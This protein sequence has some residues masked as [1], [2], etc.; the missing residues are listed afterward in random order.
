MAQLWETNQRALQA[1]QEREHRER[2]DQ[3][4]RAIGELGDGYQGIF[5]R[6]RV[7]ELDPNSPQYRNRDAI[8]HSH[9]A[10]ERNRL[11]R[12]LPP[13]PVKDLVHR[14]VLAEFPQ[15]FQASTRQE[16]TDKVARRQKQFVSR[17]KGR[18]AKP[19]KPEEAA[20]ARVEQRYQSAGWADAKPVV[21]PDVGDEV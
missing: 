21:G 17:P 3:F 19:L 9:I 20:I 12:N 11:E 10:L 18:K 2:L 4:D 14:A 6:G 15:E 5:G 8:W 16:V 7:T 13:I 1:Q